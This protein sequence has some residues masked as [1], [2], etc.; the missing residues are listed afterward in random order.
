MI[1]PGQPALRPLGAG[2][3]RSPDAGGPGYVTRVM[4]AA[5]GLAV[6]LGALTVWAL[7]DSSRIA[8]AALLAAAVLAVAAVVGSLRTVL[9]A[10][11][12]V[13]TPF[14]LDTNLNWRP[15]AAE[16]GATAGLSISLTT[17]ALGVLYALWFARLLSVQRSQAKPTGT[18]LAWPLL[19]YVGLSALSLLVASD[20]ELAQFKLFV[21]VQSL[22]LFIYLAGT[23]R[24][25]REVR[26]IVGALLVAMVAQSVIVF[27][28]R[29]AGLD[30]AFAGLTTSGGSE[31][32]RVGGTIGSPNT[33]AAFFAFLL[34]PAIAVLVS[35]AGR[36]SKRF[37]GLAF[38]TGLLALVFTE[39]RGGWIAAALALALFVWMAFRRGW[40]QPGRAV[41]LA[42]AAVVVLV[43][44]G[45][46]IAERLTADDGG[47]AASRIPL[48]QLSLDMIEDQPIQ[49][50][51]L[52]NFSTALPGYAGP[53]FVGQFL[54]AAH[55]KYLLVW[56][57]AGLLALLA[58][59]IFLLVTLR[60]GWL[61]GRSTNAYIG[62]I[63]LAL[64]FAIVGQM[65]HM[66]VEI[67]QSRP[68]VQLLWLAAGL[69]AA[70]FAITRRAEPEV[71]HG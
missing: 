16:A 57:E 25:V 66:T 43:P 46:V 41:F 7:D 63:A 13:D 20:T 10:L 34:A 3:Q 48:I 5:A 30:L 17:A 38:V 55:N 44:V 67:F 2:G 45:G 32:T 9:L 6:A 69:I 33:A 37:A 50:V 15:E 24:S 39:S 61:A 58:F 29:F 8:T 36:W 49:G 28:E 14:Q 68:Q 52:N 42:I 64:T 19:V 23:V 53:E 26:F 59:L 71:R 62:P 40:L 12:V 21:L 65:V 31:S 4:L 47:S 51:G 54:F 56:A 18:R 1:R 22:L 11:I 35:N 70:M 60:R 27:G